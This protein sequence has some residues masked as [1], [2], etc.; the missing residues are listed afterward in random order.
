MH[1]M[2]QTK[3]TKEGDAVY[4]MG[5]KTMSSFQRRHFLGNN[6][7]NTTGIS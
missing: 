3:W 2:E 1:D 4:M 5:L 7:Q 6:Q